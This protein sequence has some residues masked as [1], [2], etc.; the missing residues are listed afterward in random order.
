[1]QELSP[2][3]SGA[4]L[5]WKKCRD[6][7]RGMLWARTVLIRGKVYVGGGSTR[8]DDYLIR[9]Y[10][11]TDDKWSTLPPAPVHAFGM[12][13]LNGQLVV[14]GGGTRQDVVTRK[15]HTFD[16]SSQK[17][18]E[19]IPPMPTAHYNAAVFSQPSCLTVVGGRD[20]HQKDLSNIE[21]FIPQT[22]QWHNASPA[23]FPLSRMTTTVIHNKCFLAECTDSAIVYQLCVSVHLATTT[24]G[25]S[26]TT[27]VTT[28]WKALPEL[29]YECFA[30]GSL[31]GCLLAVGGG[32]HN[33]IST[34]Q[35]YSP[36]TNT[37]ERV[38]D[39]PD[40]R[41]VCSTVLLPTTGELLVVGGLDGP[42]SRTTKVWRA[43]ITI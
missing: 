3:P 4:E 21:I 37:W 15:V 28:E 13:E 22:S 11:I 5:K 14:V 31:N 33:P 36:I 26:V 10:S 8:D 38:G 9:Q 19:S 42:R 12:G 24:T 35:C 32:W 6:M 34:V 17:W 29:P 40:Q 18:K 20:Q 25:S 43:A 41:C 1:M 16:S 23:P 27:Q 39:L 2:F 30:L 7:P